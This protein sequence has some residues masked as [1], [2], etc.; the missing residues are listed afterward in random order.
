MMRYEW[1]VAKQTLNRRKHGVD[2]MTA[3]AALEDPRR[4]EE[5]DASVEYVEERIRIIG[6]A[7][8]IVLF[9]VASQ[10]PAL[11]DHFRP[12]GDTT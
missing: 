10:R 8:G 5:I 1:S 7:H 4:L 11:Q 2:F 9:V 3:I 12:K 6:M